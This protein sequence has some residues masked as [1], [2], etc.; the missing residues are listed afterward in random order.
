[1]R[2]V[3]LLFLL[4]CIYSSDAVLSYC[5]GAFSSKKDVFSD[6]YNSS[7]SPLTK[8][9]VGSYQAAYTMKWFD[10]KRQIKEFSDGLKKT[11][12]FLERSS[13]TQREQETLNNLVVSM[14]ILIHKTSEITEFVKQ[15]SAEEALYFRKI[16]Q[17]VFSVF[18]KHLPMVLKQDPQQVDWPRINLILQ[19]VAN[20][21]PQNPRFS[22]YKIK[23]SI[24]GR[25]SLKE[26]ILCRV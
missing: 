4:L 3:T 8:T 18:S 13:T 2:N 19:E 17:A 14:E 23:R 1:M 12:K 7:H 6:I 10:S 15:S 16:T 20:F 11:V 21:D 22:L 24:E 25:Y 5:M 9:L 26:F